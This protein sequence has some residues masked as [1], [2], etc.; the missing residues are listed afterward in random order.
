MRAVVFDRPGPPEVLH[1]ADVAAQDGQVVVNVAAAAV[2]PVDLATRSGLIP[3]PTPAVIGWD[4]IS[5]ALSARR[6][7]RLASRRATT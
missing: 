4:G 3:T 6:I 2:N 1:V 5:R 7:Q